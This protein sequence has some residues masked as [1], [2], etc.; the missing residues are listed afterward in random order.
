MSTHNFQ[1]GQRVIWIDP[2]GGARH[3]YT[4]QHVQSQDDDA[5]IFMTDD[6]G[7]ECEAYPHELEPA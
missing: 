3:P 1:I 4:I 5:V 6:H 7:S 2:D